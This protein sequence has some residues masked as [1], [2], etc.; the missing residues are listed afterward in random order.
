MNYVHFIIYESSGK[1]SLIGYAEEST[2][3]G[4]YLI[5]DNSYSLDINNFYVNENK[6][7]VQFPEKPSEFYIWNYA[8]KSWEYSEDIY[9][10]YLEKLKFT[11][12]VNRDTLLLQSDWTELPSA[13]VRL[14]ETKIAEWQTYRQALRDIT[15]QEGYPLNIVWPS[16]PN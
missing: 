2:L 12:I 10:N 15:K 13:L 11:A 1:P 6:E 4:N 9:R 8:L 14:G 5:I 16:Q 7:I 3:K